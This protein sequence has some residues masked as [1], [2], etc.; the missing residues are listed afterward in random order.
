MSLTIT[1]S[2]AAEAKLRAKAAANGQPLDEYASRVL[3]QAATTPT[4]DEVL[5]PFRQ[6]VAQS[7][8][9]NEELDAF[10]EAVRETAYRD[11]QLRPAPPT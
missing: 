10:V 11:R 7:G 1:L 8:M 6:Q 5:A 3:E 9:T 4:V 2:P